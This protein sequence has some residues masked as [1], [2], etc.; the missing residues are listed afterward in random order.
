MNQMKRAIAAERMLDNL[1]LYFEE[2]LRTQEHPLI[3][4]DEITTILLLTELPEPEEAND[5]T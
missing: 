1:H 3:G 2:L 5:G 4:K